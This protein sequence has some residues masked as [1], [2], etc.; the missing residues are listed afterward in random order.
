MHLRQIKDSLLV[1]VE[2][3][4]VGEGTAEALEAVGVSLEASGGF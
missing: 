1:A 4:G 2:E 3:M